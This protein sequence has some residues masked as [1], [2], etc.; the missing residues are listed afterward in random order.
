M[1]VI[2]GAYIYGIF[3]DKKIQ[4]IGSTK[5]FD[6]R[7]CE[8]K[9]DLKRGRDMPIY[10][11]MRELQITFDNVKCIILEGCNVDNRYER[12]RYWIEKEGV[13]SLWN[14]KIPE[15]T[16]CEHNK[17]RSRCKECGG[18]SICEHGKRRSQCKECNPDDWWCYLC[19]EPKQYAGM[20][21]LKAHMR[22]THHYVEL[23][24]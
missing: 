19:D 21:S 11:K 8:H 18:G 6:K 4:Y 17:Q 20:S 22:N 5:D 14:E 13:D 16:F 2:G 1:K 9:S 12:E 7:I 24:G 10:N 23:D 3:Y 15:G